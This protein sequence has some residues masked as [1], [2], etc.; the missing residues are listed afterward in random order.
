MDKRIRNTGLA[1]LGGLATGAKL[2]NDTAG[3]TK[4]LIGSDKKQALEDCVA[5]KPAPKGQSADYYT[6]YRLF[7]KIVG[8]AANNQCIAQ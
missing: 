6:H 3:A 5:G 4:S 1:V 8:Q 7:M 2:A